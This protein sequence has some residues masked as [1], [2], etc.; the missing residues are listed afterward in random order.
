MGKKKKSFNY[1]NH[2]FCLMNRH[3]V[4]R[5]YDNTRRDL[6]KMVEG[7]KLTIQLKRTHYN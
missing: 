3:H 5:F 1:V 7:R 6:E 2:L 4:R